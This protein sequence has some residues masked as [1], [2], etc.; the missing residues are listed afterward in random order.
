MNGDTPT[1]NRN[2]AYYM[3]GAEYLIGPGGNTNY[4]ATHVGWDDTYIYMEPE[5]IKVVNLVIYYGLSQ[6]HPFKAGHLSQ[7][8][9][10]LIVYQF[11]GGRLEQILAWFYMGLMEF[12]VYLDLLLF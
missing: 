8:L 10:I 1:S 2:T 9:L 4:P 7:H 11:N 5:L 12:I 3:E 6:N